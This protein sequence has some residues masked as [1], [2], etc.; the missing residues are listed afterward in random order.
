[1]VASIGN[2]TEKPTHANN[3]DILLEQELKPLG[4][5]QAGFFY[6]QLTNPIVTANIPCTGNCLAAVP[7]TPAGSLAQEDTNGNSARVWGL[8]IG[9]Q[10]K[11][12]NLPGA[13][14][15]LGLMTNYSYNESAINGLPNRTDSPSLMGTARHAFNV[16]P[17]YEFHRYSVH[18]GASYNA[19]YI[20]AYQYYGTASGISEC[21]NGPNPNPGPL[22]GPIN[23]PCGD[24]YFYPHF[25]VDAQM[26]ARIY[27]G[28]RLQVQGLNLT[29]EVFGF[30]NGTEQYMTQREYYKPTYEVSLVWNS[31]REK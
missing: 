5:I 22:N 12:T 29:N 19:S 3:Y 8:E 9:L 30:Y 11:Y 2:P 24:N 6:K 21:N 31:G 17:E 15:G 14:R 10:Q 16:E 25:Q 1:V 18:M 27:R 13:L 20:N 23:G 7:G 26:G 4:L 28:L